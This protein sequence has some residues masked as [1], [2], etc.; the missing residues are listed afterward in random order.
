[1]QYNLVLGNPVLFRFT[2]TTHDVWP[3]SQGPSEDRAFLYENPQYTLSLQPPP[4]EVS[5]LKY[6]SPIGCTHMF[7]VEAYCVGIAL[8]TRAVQAFYFI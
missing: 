7:V 6:I 5:R 2:S 1:M 4:N 8:P 3:M